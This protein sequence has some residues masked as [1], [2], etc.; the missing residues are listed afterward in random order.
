MFSASPNPKISWIS[1]VQL[2]P[3]CKSFV[4]EPI[5]SPFTLLTQNNVFAPQR[6][7]CIIESCLIAT[8]AL[9][10]LLL[11]DP[12]VHVVCHDSQ[13]LPVAFFLDFVIEVI[14]VI[15]ISDKIECSPKASSV[16]NCCGSSSLCPARNIL[17]A[18]PSVGS[19]PLTASA[20]FLLV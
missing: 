18:L 8:K 15:A 19:R 7:D 12:F 17:D 11:L 1:R 6:F 20:R 16:N 3:V 14:S 5:N 4:L 10:D 13:N 2:N 9:L